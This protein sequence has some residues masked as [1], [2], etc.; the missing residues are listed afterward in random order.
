[1]DLGR[2]GGLWRPG[3]KGPGARVESKQEEM[4]DEEMTGADAN[5]SRDGI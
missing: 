1:M 2:W 4:R 3:I 5:I